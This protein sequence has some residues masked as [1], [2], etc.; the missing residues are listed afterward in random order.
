VQEDLDLLGEDCWHEKIQQVALRGTPDI[1]LCLCGFFVALELK[2]EAKLEAL[3]VYKLEKIKKA[4]GI[5][6]EVTPD[7]WPKQF[8]ELKKLATK[9]RAT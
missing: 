3:Q 7:S 4:G 2:V 8:R 6:W 5:A 1:L 9:R